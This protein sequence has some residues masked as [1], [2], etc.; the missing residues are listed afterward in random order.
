MDIPHTTPLPAARTA[1]LIR[2]PVAEV[3][4]AFIDPGITTNFWFTKGS[5][6]LDAG[7]PVRWEWEMYGAS[8]EVTPK[9]IERNKRIVVE[10]DGYVGRTNVEW[11]FTPRTEDTTYVTITEW[12]W[13]GTPDEIFRYIADSTQGFT[14]TIAG[15]KA[16]LEHG[17][18]LRLVEDLH[19]DGHHCEGGSA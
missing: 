17:V 7:K 5:G 19:P 14:F 4:E 11:T 1:M 18:R 12:G 3:F 9:V 16:F 6:R 2:R 13:T 10:W 15:L 8:T